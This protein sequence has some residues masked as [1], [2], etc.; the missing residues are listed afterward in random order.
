MKRLASII[1]TLL[2]LIIGGGLLWL[3]FKNQDLSVVF[4]RIRNAN[5]YWIGLSI[6]VSIFALIS[7]AMRWKQLI[8]PLGYQPRLSS[9]FNAVMFGYAANMVFPRLGEVSRCGA[10]SKSD[11]IPFEKL[12]G[13]VI[14][15]R[16][17]DVL[18]LIV[19]IILS[20][21]FEFDRLGGFLSKHIFNPIINAVGSSFILGIILLAIVIVFIFGYRFIIKR[22]SE[23]PFINKIR[24]FLKG[25]ADGLVSVT[26][27][28][29]KWL[30]V[31][32]SLFIWSMYFLMTYVCFFALPETNGL[33]PMAGLFIMVIGAIGMTAP[34]QGGIGIYHL[35]VSE[36]IILYGLTADDGITY[37]T[38]VHSGQTL[39]LVILG[40]LSMIYLF[41]FTKP[42][43]SIK[44]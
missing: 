13:T 12:I 16:T 21:V 10:L 37:A 28:K 3:T 25:I 19:C 40:G 35:L 42:I 9:A 14:V 38:M 41:F 17:S 2:F 26:K 11:D 4:N 39:L 20:A 32:H 34:V 36:G 18:M 31:F 24:T 27:L 23:H 6:L 30:F 15:E 43:S 5:F 1:K 8:E 7:R 29:N 22:Y 44:S 33:S